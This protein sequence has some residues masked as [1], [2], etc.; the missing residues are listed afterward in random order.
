MRK[1]L[2]AIVFA[3]VAM[4][5][6]AQIY[7]GGSLGLNSSGNETSKSS[8]FSLAPEVGYELSDVLSV[9]ATVSLSANSSKIKGIDYKDSSFSW[10]ISPYA[11]YTFLKSGKFSCFVDG[12]LSLAGGK[13]RD[14][15]FG[16]F[17]EPG[18]AL[19]V[20][21]NISLIS[22]LG[23]LGLSFAGKSSTFALNAK[24]TIGTVG[25]HYIF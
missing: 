9:G 7:V 14:F 2:L 3:M 5:G 23:N 11:R 24:T 15:S 6:S 16:I 8:S 17:A 19:A 22:H 12:G 18:I 25:I 20:T 1:S 21:E 13:H 4:A 10:G